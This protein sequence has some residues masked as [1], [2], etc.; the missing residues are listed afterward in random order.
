MLSTSRTSQREM[1]S[2]KAPLPVNTCFMFC[3]L[4]TTQSG[5]FVVPAA[6]QSAAPEE[7]HSLPEGIL[8][9]HSLTAPLNSSYS[10]NVPA[11]ACP[12]MARRRAARKCPPWRILCFGRGE[13]IES[14][15]RSFSRRRLFQCAKI[16]TSDSD[17]PKFA[18]SDAPKRSV[19]CT[20]QDSRSKNW[21]WRYLST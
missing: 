7:Q 13:V 9:V 19:K 18:R 11:C 14:P 4:L 2:L 3:K 8:W 17:A 5:I 15:C 16:G 10:V 12:K 20:K 1:S 6:P 21:G